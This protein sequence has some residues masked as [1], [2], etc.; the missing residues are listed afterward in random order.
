[1]IKRS[2]STHNVKVNDWLMI[3]SAI[4]AQRRRKLALQ[5]KRI[6][7]LIEIS[8]PIEQNHQSMAA[9]ERRPTGNHQNLTEKESKREIHQNSNREGIQA[10]NPP[11]SGQ[12]KN[13]TKK[14]HQSNPDDRERESKLSVKRYRSQYSC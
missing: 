12:R 6:T 10:R 8:N 13:E 3:Q 2:N 5:K 14:N 11:K 1:M 9:I 4:T 7:S